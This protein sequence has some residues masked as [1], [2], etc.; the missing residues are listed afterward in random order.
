MAR[1]VRT[2]ER[3]PPSPPHTHWSQ[4]GSCRPAEGG[5][6]D[7]AGRVAAPE[8]ATWLPAAS[9]GTCL[10]GE[11]GCD[12]RGPHRTGGPSLCLRRADPGRAVGGG[13]AARGGG[14]GQAARASPAAAKVTLTPIRPRGDPENAPGVPGPG[15]GGGWCSGPAGRSPS[16]WPRGRPAPQVRA[17]PRVPLGRSGALAPWASGNNLPSVFLLFFCFAP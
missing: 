17:P 4:L 13:T 11:A 1:P 12:H 14:E 9:P 6:R 10:S 2:P 7:D 8:E 5:S 16:L 3:A 15:W